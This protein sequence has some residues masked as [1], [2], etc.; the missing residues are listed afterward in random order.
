MST[1]KNY[2]KIPKN[3]ASQDD[4]DFEFLRKTGIEY[5]EAMGGGVWSDLNDHD[6]GVTSLEVISY[7]ITDLAAR[8][9]LPIETLIASEDDLELRNQFYRAEEILPS[10]P[11]TPLDYRKKFIDI[12]GVRNCWIIPYKELKLHVNCEENLLSYRGFDPKLLEQSSSILQGLNCLLVDFEEDVDVKSVVQVIREVYHENRNLCEDL[13]VIK[14]IVEQPISVCATMDIDRSADQNKIHAQIIDVINQYFSTQIRRYT[15]K[16]MREKGYRMDEIFEGPLL[17]NGFIDS[18]ELEEASLRSEV[19]L[20]DIINLIMSIDGVKSISSIEIKGCKT[21]ATENGSDWLICIDERSKPVLA[22]TPDQGEPHGDCELQS[23]FNYKKDVLPVVY[24]P[25]AVQKELDMIKDDRDHQNAL[26]VLDKFPVIPQGS[27]LE[28]GETT[29]IMNDF[30]ETYGIGPYGLPKTVT[31]KRRTQAKQLK[32]YLLFFDQIL[33]SYF[34]HLGNVK[35]LFSMNSGNAP[36][37]FTQAIKDVKGFEE[38]VSDYPADNDENL[39]ENLMSF[40]DENVARRNELLDHLLARFAE[41]FSDYSFIVMQMY[42]E[43]AEEKLIE[44]KEQ[45]LAEY[46]ELSSKRGKGYNYLGDFWDT[47]NISGVQRRVSRLTGIEDYSRRNLVDLGDAKWLVPASKIEDIYAWYLPDNNEDALIKGISEDQP[48]CAALNESL[49]VFSILRNANK[50][51]LKKRL[52]KELTK[53]LIYEEFRFQVINGITGISYNFFISLGGEEVARS[54]NY[55]S[56][57]EMYDGLMGIIDYLNTEDNLDK[58]STPIPEEGMFVVE[59]ILLRPELNISKYQDAFLPVCADDCEDQCGLDP[60]SFRA[61]I[62]LPGTGERFG[63]PDFRNFMDRF[64]REELPAHVLPRICWIDACQLD[65]FQQR[66]RS[67]LAE[68]KKGSIKK[69]TLTAFLDIFGKLKNTYPS[70]QLFDCESEDLTG[71]I[72][73]GRS[74]I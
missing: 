17:D 28:I 65:E 38:L 54:I 52:S 23:V 27:N 39:T 20:S 70:G 56:T 36:S 48:K 49:K 11:L 68:R 3:I 5:I 43:N 72:I 62:I 12:E 69:D 21:L 18:K 58:F 53:E 40:L 55:A 34:A 2:N 26:A 33:S 45:F 73:L 50:A 9:N 51:I 63:N 4:L 8:I 10:C 46:V 57:A 42:N 29:T 60:Y 13:V 1:I 6:P 61:S 24:N 15:L 44:S 74:N 41:N 30:P 19:R 64:I 59:H 25:Q 35:N 7:A 47:T 32:G 37:Y 16:E 71:K 66:Y 22:N 31:E 67:L 14:R